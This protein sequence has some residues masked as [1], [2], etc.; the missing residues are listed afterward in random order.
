ML[1]SSSGSCFGG[2]TGTIARELGSET[3]V[4]FASLGLWAPSCSRPWANAVRKS[5]ETRLNSSYKLFS[6]SFWSEEAEGG[7][8][9]GGGGGRVSSQKRLSCWWGPFGKISWFW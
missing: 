9:G 3:A 5:W 1:L 4:W 6:L 7:G 8:G 2:G